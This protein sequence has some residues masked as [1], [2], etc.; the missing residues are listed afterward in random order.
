MENEVQPFS[1]IKKVIALYKGEL[2]KKESEIET[3]GQQITVL[4]KD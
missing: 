4:I 2:Q 3:L 1:K